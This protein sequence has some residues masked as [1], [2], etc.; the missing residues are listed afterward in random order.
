MPREHCPP[1]KLMR[2]G[3]IIGRESGVGVGGGKHLPS[4]KSHYDLAWAASPLWNKVWVT[5][6]PE[7]SIGEKDY[8]ASRQIGGISSPRL[9]SGVRRKG[10]P[11]VSLTDCCRVWCALGSRRRIS[12]GARGPLPFASPGITGEGAAGPTEADQR[13]VKL[14]TN[15]R[16]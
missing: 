14:P 13:R 9:L 2:E 10:G 7:R 16:G 5:P 1:S 6:R 3:G 11:R 12:R 8:V 4:Y 15:P